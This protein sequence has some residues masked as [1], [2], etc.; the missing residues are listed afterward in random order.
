MR[1]NNLR[2]IISMDKLAGNE[3]IGSL[4]ACVTED[5]T[6]IKVVVKLREESLNKMGLARVGLPVN[7]H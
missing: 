5:N 7:Y 2:I 1:C 3:V 4:K 6:I